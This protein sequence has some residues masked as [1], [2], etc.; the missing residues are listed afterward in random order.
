MA[1]GGRAV[2]D[3][4]HI[5]WRTILIVGVTNRAEPISLAGCYSA[6]FTICSCT[7]AGGASP[8]PDSG[9]SYCTRLPKPRAHRP[10]QPA[11]RLGHL[12][13]RHSRQASHPKPRVR[14]L[15]RQSR[16][17]TRSRHPSNYEHPYHCT[18]PGNWPPTRQGDG[19]MPPD[20]GNESYQWRRT[21]RLRRF[22]SPS[23][24]CRANRAEQ[25]E[26]SKRD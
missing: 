13:H 24:Q 26:P 11:H 10:S 6:A 19:E 22:T 12:T 20:R 3:P 16:R 14:R 4:P 5:A 18:T 1:V 21:R 7:T 17:Q 25:A 15:T 23:R 9:R 8:A 2:T